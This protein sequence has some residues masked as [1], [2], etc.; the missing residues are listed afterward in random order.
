MRSMRGRPERVLGVALTCTILHDYWVSKRLSTGVQRRR[1][2]DGGR[3]AEES[4][5]DAKSDGG[6]KNVMETRCAGE[7]PAT[8]GEVPAAAGR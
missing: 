2:E 6:R 8:T 3:R 1:A 5:G 4:H 7:S